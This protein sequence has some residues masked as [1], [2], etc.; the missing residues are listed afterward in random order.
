[1]NNRDFRFEVKD[2]AEDGTFQ[3]LLS[4]Y[5]VLDHGGDV[6]EKGAFTKTLRESKGIVP[7]LWQHDKSEPIGLLYLEDSEKALKARGELA[8]DLPTAR[9]AHTLLKKGIVKGMSIGYETVKGPMENGVRRLKEIKLWEGS[10]VT[11]PMNPKAQVT[12]VKSDEDF[13]VALR[14]FKKSVCEAR[15]ELNAE[16]RAEVDEVIQ[17]LSALLKTEAAAPAVEPEFIH[18]QLSQFKSEILE[19]LQW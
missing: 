15:R 4:V 17:T 11:F 10:L 5:D 13:A 8:L 19:V 9:K 6:V 18:S 3:G 2:V 12:S 16:T 14:E 1:M 7:L